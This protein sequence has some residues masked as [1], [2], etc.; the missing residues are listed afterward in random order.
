LGIL[1]D[2]IPRLFHPNPHQVVS[3]PGFFFGAGMLLAVTIPPAFEYVDMVVK[4]FWQAVGVFSFLGL[5][6]LVAVCRN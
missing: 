3:E 2:S 6:G 5:V 4:H 1:R